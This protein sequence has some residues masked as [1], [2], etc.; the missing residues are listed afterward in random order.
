MLHS[1]GAQISSYSLFLGLESQKWVLTCK[2][3]RRREE[4]TSD[5]SW[6]GNSD[7]VHV[8]L[9]YTIISLPYNRVKR[10]LYKLH[11]KKGKMEYKSNWA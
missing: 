11:G 1:G 7:Y 10:L 3:R 8:S 2:G 5:L 9:F 6:F 4:T